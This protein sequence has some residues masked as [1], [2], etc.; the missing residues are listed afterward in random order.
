MNEPLDGDRIRIETPEHV[1]F[2]YELA[3]FV[4]RIMAGL[5]DLILLGFLLFGLLIVVTVIVGGPKGLAPWGLALGLVAAFIILWGYP[6]VFE[7]FW[8]GQTPGKRMLGMRVIQEGGYSL[9]PQVVIVRNLVRVVDFLPGG[10][11]LGL[12]VMMLNRRY[13]RVGDF[14]AGTIVI[15]ERSSAAVP[16]QLRASIPIPAGEE[17]RVAE[18]RR[19]GVHQLDPAVLQLVR[20]FMSRRA[21]LNPDARVRVA[22]RLCRT[23]SGILGI[24]E[25]RG[26]KL[27]ACVLAAQSQAEQKEPGAPPLGGP[28]P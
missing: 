20:D 15:R 21:S 14:V 7:I 3:G 8:K 12:F 9:T 16:P 2:E 13:K 27:L 17:E 4:S 23:I 25:E 26:E 22:D 10:Y 18:L 6:I 28:L 24:P 19:L 11:F 5:L 1:V